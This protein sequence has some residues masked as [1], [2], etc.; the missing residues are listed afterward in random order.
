MDILAFLGELYLQLE[1]DFQ[2]I[3][4]LDFIC[5]YDEMMEEDVPHFDEMKF[6]CFRAILQ[7]DL[8]YSFKH[9]VKL[10]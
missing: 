8:D 2:V 3:P 6:K 1:E 5:M 7:L 4:F 10:P 9:L